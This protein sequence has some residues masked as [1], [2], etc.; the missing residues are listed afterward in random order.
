MPN[1]KLTVAGDSNVGLVR[2]NNEDY[3]TYFEPGDPLVAQQLGRLYIVA[4]GVGGAATGE[5]AS[6]YAARKVLYTYFHQPTLKPWQRIKAAMKFANLDLMAYIRQ[7]AQARMATTMVAAALNSDEMTIVNVGDSRA[8]L[9]RNQQVR[10][11]TQDH[12]LVNEMIRNNVITEEQAKTARVKN[13]L[14]SSL[15]GHDVFKAD[16]FVE[17]LVPGD[18]VIMASDGF[19]RYAEDISIVQKLALSGTPEQ[20]VNNGIQFAR[21][22]GG[23]D[24]ITIL[25]IRVDG[26]VDFLP[27]G[28]DTG[29]L[30][31]PLDLQTVVSDPLTMSARSPLQ[32]ETQSPRQPASALFHP[33]SSVT[34]ISAAEALSVPG[35]NMAYSDTDLEDTD[36]LGKHP[37]ASEE[38]T[39]VIMTISDEDATQQ[40]PIVLARPAAAP[41]PAPE[42][43]PK[44]VKKSLI[45]RPSVG[46]YILMILA[47]FV[48]FVV[49]GVLALTLGRRFLEQR[50]QPGGSSNTP[51]V[52]IID[53]RDIAHDDMA[54]DLPTGYFSS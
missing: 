12:N 44:P 48:V 35:L 37:A 15:G 23:Q 39:A 4:D 10:Q 32:E 6:K 9:F 3:L 14:T 47:A 52:M 31:L 18:I 43:S 46:H 36:E 40:Q 45:E 29:A 34:P 22:S 25:V 27:A 17:K 20:I 13:Q 42:V 38:T 7:N 2:K 49:L 28:A 50:T 11:I 5:V 51:T 19:H 54:L 16:V 33:D 1:L 8:Y 30:P 21:K 24:N 26:Y 41:L 53:S